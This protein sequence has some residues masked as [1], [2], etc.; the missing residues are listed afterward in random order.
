MSQLHTIQKLGFLTEAAQGAD[1]I[2]DTYYKFG[3]AFRPIGK[4]PNM[5]Y[6]PHVTYRGGSRD[7]YDIR[8]TYEG[9]ASLAY[10]PVNGLGLYRNYG[11]SATTANVHRITG[12]DSGLLPTDTLRWQTESAG[13]DRRK[14]L[15][16]AK[17]KT[18][19]FRIDQ[20][21]LTY[22]SAG[23]TFLAERLVDPTT[24]TSIEPTFPNSESTPYL[25]DSNFVFKWGVS[26]DG[27][28]EF[29]SGGVDYSN[30]WLSGNI[31]FDSFNRFQKVASQNYP[32]WV[33]ELDR[34]TIL[35]F[36]I[37]RGD[38]MTIADDFD[39]QISN[40]FADAH[41]KIYNGAA[42]YQQIDFEQVVMLTCEENITS[43]NVAD[44]SPVWDVSAI[45][46]SVVANVKDGLAVGLYGE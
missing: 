1:P 3:R 27:N 6:N 16:G 12:I 40:T 23:E 31:I 24:S 17:S 42:N 14:S 20:T 43:E 11:S 46:K 10:A 8:V 30:D 18:Y 15:V 19:L 39:A 22:A 26:L 38:D 34:S 33:L 25:P 28:K 13:A 4:F 32:K 21:P 44:D 37:L 2:T 41:L 45:V 35:Q 36:S 7:P 5:K 29:S 9:H